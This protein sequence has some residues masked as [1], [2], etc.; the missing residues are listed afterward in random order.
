LSILF[1]DYIQ[2]ILKNVVARG[3]QFR[4]LAKQLQKK[5]PDLISDVR[6]FGLINGIEIN[7]ASKVT[8]ADITK[9][10]LAAKVLVVPAGPTVVRFVPPLI[11]SEAEIA[12]VINRFETALV[13]LKK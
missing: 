8:A 6:G 11:I 13:S 5:M 12:E 9:A 7:E 2:N 3:E 1:F 4:T 10:L